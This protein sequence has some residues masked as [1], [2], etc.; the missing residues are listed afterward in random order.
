ML[1]T[2]SGMSIFIQTEIMIPVFI[3]RRLRSGVFKQIGKISLIFGRGRSCDRSHTQGMPG[4]V[5]NDYI[6]M[7]F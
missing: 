6:N 7:K 2:V 3:F 5:F 4:I 1:K